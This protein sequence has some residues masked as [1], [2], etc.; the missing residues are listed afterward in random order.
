MQY[1]SA[2]TRGYLEEFKQNIK[3]IDENSL[4][5]SVSTVA[6]DTSISCTEYDDQFEG[7][8]YRTLK[9]ESQIKINFVSKIF[10]NSF[11]SK[12]LADFK[13]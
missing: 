11:H 8:F 10:Y 7:I 5:Y 6:P 1:V 4:D 2:Q 3:K 13:V 12:F 9:E